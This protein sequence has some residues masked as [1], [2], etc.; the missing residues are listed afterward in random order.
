M[1]GKGWGARDGRDEK[2]QHM[3]RKEDWQRRKKDEEQGRE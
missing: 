2:K 1:G 3:K